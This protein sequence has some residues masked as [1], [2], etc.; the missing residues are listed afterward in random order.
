MI[1]KIDYNEEKDALVIKLDDKLNVVTLENSSSK[2]VN[3]IMKALP[4]KAIVT[5][6]NNFK[7]EAE[8]RKLI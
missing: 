6:Y 5:H 4:D 3:A 8:E 2:L 7:A 1:E